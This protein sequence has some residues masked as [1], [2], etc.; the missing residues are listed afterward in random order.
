VLT[1]DMQPRP[2]EGVIA[3]SR[4]DTDVGDY[5]PDDREVHL[6][7]CRARWV[8]RAD[9]S[10]CIVDQK[11]PPK[12]RYCHACAAVHPEPLNVDCRHGTMTGAQR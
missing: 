12:L 4:C 7:K 5:L 6:A 10:W 2:G 8:Q 1:D 3:C 9:G 11:A